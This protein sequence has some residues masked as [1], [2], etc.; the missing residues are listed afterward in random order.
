M[1]SL[2]SDQDTS[3][4]RNFIPK[5]CPKLRSLTTIPYILRVYSEV[6]SKRGL[7]DLAV[8]KFSLLQKV[9]IVKRKNGDPTRQDRKHVGKKLEPA[10]SLKM[11]SA[12]PK[13]T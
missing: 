12:V 7:T 1:I 8:S 4:T 9:I 13:M 2:D 5:V 10:T 11:T 3:Q 6:R